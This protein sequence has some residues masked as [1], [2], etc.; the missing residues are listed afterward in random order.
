MKKLILASKSP[1]RRQLL[2]NLGVLFDIIPSRAVE[3]EVTVNDPGQLVET[4]ALRKAEAVASSMPDREERLV[5][6]ADTIVVL[7]GT[8]LGKPKNDQEAAAML[9]RLS[10]NWHQVFT[11]VAVFATKSGSFD[12]AHEQTAVKIRSLSGK[13][14]AAYVATGEPLDKAGAYGIQA[15][16]ALLV[17]RIDG[18]YF[19]VVGLPLVKLAELLARYGVDLLTL[20]EEKP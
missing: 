1:R 8:I 20:G 13:E 17:E 11:G 6:G 4:L 18:C 15:K 7:D 14:I 3:A 10:G 5:I 12:S 16:G 9:R 19:N 2:A